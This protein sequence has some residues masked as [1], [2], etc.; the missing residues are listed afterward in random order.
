LAWAGSS[1]VV[2]GRHAGNSARTAALSSRL[3]DTA[4]LIAIVVI[5]HMSP[6]SAATTVTAKAVPSNSS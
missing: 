5:I 2:D 1:S 3:A 4:R 6:T